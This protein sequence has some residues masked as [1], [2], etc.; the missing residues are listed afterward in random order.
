M[1][2]KLV[3]TNEACCKRSAHYKLVEDNDGYDLIQLKRGFQ[4]EVGNL[5]LEPGEP[6]FVMDTGKLYIG[7]SYGIPILINGGG[8]NV[9]SSSLATIGDFE[10]NSLIEVPYSRMIT[11][12]GITPTAADAGIYLILSVLDSNKKPIGEAALTNWNYTADSAQFRYGSYK[13]IVEPDIIKFVFVQAEPA[14]IWTISSSEITEDTILSVKVLG[15]DDSIFYPEW[16]V[17][18]TVLYI[19]LQI[20]MTGTAIIYLGV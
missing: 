1:K 20:P 6:A 19:L 13:P 7:N 2:Y 8:T 18:G 5:R 15:P 12:N 11:A 16:R 9:A 17:S 3:Q 4:S 10:D 14:D